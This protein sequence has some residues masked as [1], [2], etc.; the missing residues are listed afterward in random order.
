MNIKIKT[1]PNLNKQEQDKIRESIKENGG[2]CPCQ[3]DKN[4]NTKCICNNFLNGKEKECHC[5]LYIKI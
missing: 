5:G 3:I 1:N 2:Y 4:E